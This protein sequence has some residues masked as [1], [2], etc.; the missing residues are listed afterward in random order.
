MGLK[1]PWC[2]DFSIG[3]LN[4]RYEGYGT[5]IHAAWKP[6]FREMARTNVVGPKTLLPSTNRVWVV[7][8]PFLHIG[9]K[10]RRH[11]R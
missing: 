8:L 3:R 2:V 6:T 4:V 7:N 1:R 10:R 11:G 9:W 5:G